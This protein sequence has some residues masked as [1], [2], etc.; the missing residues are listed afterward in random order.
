MRSYTIAAKV[1]WVSHQSPTPFANRRTLMASTPNSPPL[2]AA[3]KKAVADKYSLIIWFFA[4]NVVAGSAGLWVPLISQLNGSHGAVSSRVAELLQAGGGYTFLIAYLATTS[5]YVVTEYVDRS[6]RFFRNQKATLLGLVLI[7]GLISVS[8]TA[9]LFSVALVSKGAP[10]TIAV[11]YIQIVMAL[12]AVVLGFLL[13]LLQ[14]AGTYGL[15][16]V[17]DQS[18]EKDQSTAKTMMSRVRPAGTDRADEFVEVNGKKVK[19]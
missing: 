11:D 14:W 4:I 12:I 8:C 5:G 2:L 7:V 1:P 13:A 17:V 9:S 19:V 15:D 18:Q 16:A 10:E 6:N 3:V